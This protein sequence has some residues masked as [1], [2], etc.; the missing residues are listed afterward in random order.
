MMA[1]ILSC[2][3]PRPPTLQADSLPAEP[4]GKPKNTAVG[5]LSVL[6]QVF[7]TLES[8][9]GLLH[10]RQILYQL[11]YHG[12]PLSCFSRVQLFATHWTVAG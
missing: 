12:S 9:Q 2:F 7:P 5:S 3:K 10:Y 8:N 1:C 6:Q 11:S 4:Q